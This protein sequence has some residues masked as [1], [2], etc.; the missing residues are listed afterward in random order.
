MTRLKD[1]I[2]TLKAAAGAY[3][4]ARKNLTT[5]DRDPTAIERSKVS[6]AEN[7]LLEEVSRLIGKKVTIV[8]G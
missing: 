6:T 7:K 4:L 8:G 3:A 5:H 1:P 2:V